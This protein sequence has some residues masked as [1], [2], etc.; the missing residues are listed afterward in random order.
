MEYIWKD[1]ERC[2]MSLC[3]KV[4]PELNMVLYIGEGLLRP[5][6]FFVLEEAVFL[7]NHRQHDMITLVDALDITTYF[8]LED[9]HRFIDNILNTAKNGIKPGPYVMITQ[10]Q[11]IHVLAKAV[12]LMAGTVDLKIKVCDTLEDAITGLGLSDHKQ[13]IIQLWKECKAASSR[14]DGTLA[15]IETLK[16]AS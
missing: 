8:E 1:R 6:D 13:E 12:E 15:K 16:K 14:A 9:I 3:Y 10:D 5:S 7:E 2:A 4:S 11:G